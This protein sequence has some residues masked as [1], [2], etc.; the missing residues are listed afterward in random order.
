MAD[1]ASVKSL[2]E[3]RFLN[4]TR[5]NFD[6]SLLNEDPILEGGSTIG[7][8]VRHTSGSIL[9]S[10]F[11]LRNLDFQHQEQ[12][13]YWQRIEIR[14]ALNGEGWDDVVR[15]RLIIPRGIRNMKSETW[16]K[17]V[18]RAFKYHVSSPTSDVSPLYWSASHILEK[19]KQCQ[20]PVLKYDHIKWYGFTVT[21]NTIGVVR[22][23]TLYRFPTYGQLSRETLDHIARWTEAEGGARIVDWNQVAEGLSSELVGEGDTDKAKDLIREWASYLDPYAD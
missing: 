19:L 7:Q 6:Y 17:Y 10:I 5:S 3:Q 13:K 4:F 1:R 21:N 9:S 23:W 18:L 15:C 12:Q 8:L 16:Q 11:Y 22:I 2:T 14:E 20:I